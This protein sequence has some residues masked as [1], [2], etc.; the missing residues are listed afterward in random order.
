MEGG[1]Y[2]GTMLSKLTLPRAQ[3]HAHS[4]HM[5]TS[6]V[7]QVTE[8]RTHMR[9]CPVRAGAL[10]PGVGQP[11]LLLWVSVVYMRYIL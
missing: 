3:L 5:P 9:I 8:V 7:H 1:G 10:S 2:V 11:I 4:V 6:V